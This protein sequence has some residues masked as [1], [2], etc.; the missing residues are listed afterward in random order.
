M[1]SNM[2]GEDIAMRVL[3]HHE[4]IRIR[5]KNS[6]CAKEHIR[7]FCRYGFLRRRIINRAAAAQVARIVEP[8]VNREAQITRLLQQRASA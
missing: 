6:T 1:S 3:L 7:L 4:T 2:T 5:W 8:Q